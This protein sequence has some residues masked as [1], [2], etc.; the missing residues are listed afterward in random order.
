MGLRAVDRRTRLRIGD[1][2]EIQ[3]PD[4]AT[5]GKRQKPMDALSL[6]CRLLWRL[7]FSPVQ[8]KPHVYSQVVSSLDL[9]KEG[10]DG[11]E[12]TT[13]KSLSTDTMIIDKME[14]KK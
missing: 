10:V 4:A 3:S 8:V 14:S 7:W 2:A 5:D 11:G 9:G 13:Y 12:M 6:F 1:N